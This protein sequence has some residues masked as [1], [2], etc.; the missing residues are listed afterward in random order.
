MFD[1]ILPVAIALAGGGQV[2]NGGFLGTLGG[3]AD[4]VLRTQSPM[5][6]GST[7]GLGMRANLSKLGD[8]QG[9]LSAGGEFSFKTKLGLPTIQF[10]G[11]LELRGDQFVGNSYLGWVN[12]AQG[13]VFQFRYYGLP[14]SGRTFSLDILGLVPLE[15][16]PDWGV[17]FRANQTFQGNS[18]TRM[19]VGVMWCPGGPFSVE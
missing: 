5:N 10:G 17:Y 8:L 9:E 14:L 11:A 2:G 12:V 6:S 13:A 1:P 19:T 15:D 4:V 7:V 18:S 3:G 16:V